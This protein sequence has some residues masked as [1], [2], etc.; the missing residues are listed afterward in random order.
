MAA[1]SRWSRRWAGWLTAALVVAPSLSGPGTALAQD[2]AGAQK[3]LAQARTR[4]A[5]GRKA[6]GEALAQA[7]KA[8]SDDLTQALA[9]DPKLL[10][11]AWE[12]ADLD[13]LTSKGRESALRG[14][15]ALV[16]DG[17][18][19]GW[20]GALATARLRA[21]DL[22]LRG[23]FEACGKAL[24]KTRTDAL[25]LLVRARTELLMGDATRALV[26]VEVAYER[27]ARG[28]PEA[29]VLHARARRAANDD[30]VAARKDL[31]QALAADPS[32]AA[33]LGL[34]ALSLCESLDKGWEADADRALALDDHEPAA[35]LAKALGLGFEEP[36]PT[37]RTV[38][39]A[40]KRRQARDHLDR[41]V[42]RDDT[43]VPAL[44]ARAALAVRELAWDEALRDAS[45][46]LAIAPMSARALALRGVVFLRQGELERAKVQLDKALE[47]DANLELALLARGEWSIATKPPQWEDAVKDLDRYLHLQPDSPEAYFLRGRAKVY[48]RRR[49][50]FAE[51]VADL[52]KAI[53]TADKD[54]SWGPT[55][56]LLR[57]ICH[58]ALKNYREAIAD[59]DEA[60]ALAGPHAASDSS[61][62]KVLRKQREAAKEALAELE[63]K[64]AE[65]KKAPEEKKPPEEKRPPEEKKSEPD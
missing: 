33:A 12:L 31:D 15:L 27:G 42:D 32:C 29:L 14:H 56:Y 11:A 30:Q 39:D 21:L 3:L 43:L 13:E 25:P 44:L 45:R 53:E 57:G 50:H 48:A 24:E 41:A 16:R 2:P 61:D 10:A 22:D 6:G 40:A 54:V 46:V 9:L 18:P 34:R 19:D 64:A 51:A 35:L 20:L 52:T 38:K 58:Q 47:L 55:A 23:A 62:L 37:G 36:T 17:D 59:Y 1:R 8:A 5:D 65:G 60:E 4:L 28:S 26:D 63:R 49:N 7:R